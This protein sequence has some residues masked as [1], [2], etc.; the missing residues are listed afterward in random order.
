MQIFL[1]VG[2]P[3]TGSTT[4][5]KGLFAQHPEI[6]YL[7]RP[8][9]E[10]FWELERVILTASDSEFGKR[11]P[12]LAEVV[13][14]LVRGASRSPVVLSHEGFLRS[15]RHGGHDVLR[16]ADRIRRV[17]AGLEQGDRRVS[18]MVCIRKQSDLF[19]SHFVQFVRG[20]QNDLDRQV[21]RLLVQPREGFAGT[22]FFDEVLGHYQ[23]LFGD[24]L[25]VL[26]FEGMSDAPDAH[27]R[28][29][30]E[31]LGVD[32]GVG[33]E[34][35]AGRHEKRKRRDQEFYLV[36]ARETPT[37]RAG[38]LLVGLGLRRVGRALKRRSFLRVALSSSQI[39]A[40]GE[41]FVESN[42]AT[43]ERF[44]LP[45]ARHGYAI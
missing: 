1:H 25:H 40:I 19:L 4:L 2:Y 21:E 36:E 20:D 28:R 39:A 45:L 27:M 35:S 14:S 9:D 12:R 16:T 13:E 18:V 34:L 30:C 11:L 29:V 22:L 33:A 37:F 26:L 41:V 5:Q 23:S 31:I 24:A 8:F 7:G 3:K 15:T 44:E 38:A 43:Q 10:E 6:A 42:R 17:F 32:A